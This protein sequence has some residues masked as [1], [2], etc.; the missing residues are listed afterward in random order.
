[1]HQHHVC[2]GVP[3][4]LDCCSCCLRAAHSCCP[5]TAANHPCRVSWISCSQR[6]IP[7]GRPHHQRVGSCC[8]QS[9]Q[10]RAQ[11][12][13]KC[14]SFALELATSSHGA[15]HVVHHVIHA[16][17][18]S[19]YAATPAANSNS[20]TPSA[21]A[22]AGPAAAYRTPAAAAAPATPVDEWR[23]ILRTIEATGIGKG[24]A[25]ATC[26]H[27]RG[28]CLWFAPLLLPLCLI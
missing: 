7:T 2:R 3:D 11:T 13:F 22:A 17:H 8:L 27:H 12:R 21:G 24:M 25:K 15:W 1:M 10:V 20:Y 4:G 16:E 14:K 6:L 26:A 28:T 18:P 5:C 23:T 19:D 9:T